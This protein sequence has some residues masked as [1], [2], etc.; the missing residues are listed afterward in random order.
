MKKKLFFMF[1]LMAIFIV[2]GCSKKNGASNL[3]EEGKGWVVTDNE[4]G[5]EDNTEDSNHS[6]SE[7]DKDDSKNNEISIDELIEMEIR[8]SFDYFWKETGTD[9]NSGGYGLNRDGNTGDLDFASIASTGYALSAYALGAHKGYISFEEGKERSLNT[10][11]TFRD[12]LER[13]DGFYYHFYHLSTGEKYD[14]EVS[15]IDT[16]LFLC[17]AIVAGEYFGEEVKEVME[18]IYK[19]IQWD[20]IVKSSN[21]FYMAYEKDENGNLKK[22][23][24]WDVAAEQFMMYILGAGSPTHPVSGDLFYHF[25]RWKATYGEHSF[26]RSWSN[27]LFAYQFSHAYIDFRDKRDS[28]GIDWFEN[29]VQAALASR[30]YSIDKKEVSKTYHENSWGLTACLGK[31]GYNGMYGAEPNGMPGGQSLGANDGT[32]AFYGAIAS[33]PFT[34]EYSK[35]AMLNYYVNHPE[36]WGPYGF[37][38]SYNLDQGSDGHIT[39]SYLGIDKGITLVQLANYEDGFIWD[40]FM[41]NEYVQEG[42]KACSIQ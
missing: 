27:S 38:E 42:M 26:I 23:G 3:P 40:L 39:K 29:S 18:D 1:L 34:P 22:V 25:M 36:S 17:G 9:L 7:E 15:T 10:L 37:Y 21:R 5:S 31:N 28:K 4:D 16:A 33:M 41:A 24:E 30:Q 32:I 12:N 14:V 35:E 8:G 13:V 11:L 2:A 6:T 20:E 19:S